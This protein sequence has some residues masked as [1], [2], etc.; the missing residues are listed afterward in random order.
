MLAHTCIL[1]AMSLGSG[2]GLDYGSKL[3]GSLSEV[4]PRPDPAAPQ[5]Q[6][7][8]CWALQE[9]TESSWWRTTALQ[10]LPLR[11]LHTPSKRT[12]E[13]QVPRVCA[14]VQGSQSLPLS[15]CFLV[16]VRSPTSSSKQ[17][18]WETPLLSQHPKGP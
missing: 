16:M 15:P 11:S 7:W 9:M 2:R 18:S 17:P 3:G 1:G 6:S 10:G 12:G 5:V 13:D 4:P 8:L 14:V